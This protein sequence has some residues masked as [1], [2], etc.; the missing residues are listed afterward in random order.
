MCDNDQ[1]Q[2]KV[3]KL[4]YACAMFSRERIRK[5]LVKI[6]KENKRTS[7]GMGQNV[8]QQRLESLASN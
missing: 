3:K 7:F 8:T 6:N 5:K 4:C 1:S 2:F